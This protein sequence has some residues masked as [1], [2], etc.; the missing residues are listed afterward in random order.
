MMSVTEDVVLMSYWCSSWFALHLFLSWFRRWAVGDTMTRYPDDY[1]SYPARDGDD[2]AVEVIR[3]AMLSK[4]N[5]LVCYPGDSVC[6]L[7]GNG[8]RKVPGYMAVTGWEYK[9]I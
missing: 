6:G 7:G 5:K 2:E 3:P 1:L 9:K 8:I 4:H